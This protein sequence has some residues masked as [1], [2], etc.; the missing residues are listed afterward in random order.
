MDRLEGV[1]RRKAHG[2]WTAAA[3]QPCLH[4]WCTRDLTTHSTVLPS[5]LRR[6]RCSTAR[7]CCARCPCKPGCQAQHRHASRPCRPPEV[8]TWVDALPGQ[9]AVGYLA[10]LRAGCACCQP[11]PPAPCAISKSCDLPACC[12]RCAALDSSSPAA[13]GGAQHAGAQPIPYS[14][15]APSA[16]GE[17]G[18]LGSEAGS[19]AR[20]S[21]APV[22]IPG[23]EQGGRR[24]RSSGDLWGMHQVGWVQACAGMWG[25]GGRYAGGARGLSV[26]RGVP[27]A[28]LCGASQCWQLW[29]G[30]PTMCLQLLPAD[31]VSSCPPP[32]CL[33]PPDSFPTC[34]RPAAG[35]AAQAPLR[36]RR[37]P[38]AAT[39]GTAPLAWHCRHWLAHHRWAGGAGCGAASHLL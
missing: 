8:S 31:H 20:Q 10:V 29:L 30:A 2:V 19:S 27:A 7:S 15:L 26:F 14:R 4:C 3:S 22:S 21:S 24:M 35:R 25:G 18:Q 16:E 34:L 12:A 23:R 6:L 32:A 1:D 39:W 9:A 33:A 37:V 28:W 36:P 11:A 13:G 38:P 17:E 5:V